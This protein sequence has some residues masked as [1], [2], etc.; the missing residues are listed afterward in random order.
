MNRPIL[1]RVL[2]PLAVLVLVEALLRLGYWESMASPNSRI[3]ATVRL[4]TRLAQEREPFQLVTLGNSRAELGL[5]EDVLQAMAN[6]HGQRHVRATLRGAN[7][8]TW[9]TL[10]EWL[11][12]HYP[13]VD[14]AIIAVS[15]GDLLWTNNGSFEVRMVEPIR[16]GLWPSR[17]ARLIFDPNDSDSYA[18]WSSLLAYRADLADYVRDPTGRQQQLA[19]A[20]QRSPSNV[21]ASSSNNICDLPIQSLASCAAGQPGTIVGLNIVSECKQANQTLATREDWRPPLAPPIRKERQAVATLRRLQLQGMPYRRPVVV[22]MPVLK[23]WRQDAFPPG[24]EAWVKQMFEPLVASGRITLID[25]TDFFDAAP[26]GECTAFYDLY[27]QTPD[28][29]R[30]LT[31]Y[32]VPQIEAALY[33]SAQRAAQ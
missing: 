2:L 14:N 19:R 33:D 8:L 27:H 20:A 12:A 4:K 3:G 29:S 24:H 25:A 16:Q 32:L 15:V 18:I 28:A 1:I 11:K 17:E 31:E 10:A 30:A 26:G 23:L 21:R 22:L 6:R 5:D 7:W 9:V 13:D